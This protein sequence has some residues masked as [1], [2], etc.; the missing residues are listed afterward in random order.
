MINGQPSGSLAGCCAGRQPFRIITSKLKRY[1]AASR[2][3]LPGI[4]HD[5][6]PSAHIRIEIRISLLG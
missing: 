1:S 4:T 3:I 2:T 6:Q 5:T